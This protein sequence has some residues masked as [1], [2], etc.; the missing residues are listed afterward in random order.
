MC[1]YSAQTTEQNHIFDE[2]VLK[3]IVTF[4]LKAYQT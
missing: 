4:L 2:H 3:L 1:F